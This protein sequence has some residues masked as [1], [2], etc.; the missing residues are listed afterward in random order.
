MMCAELDT[1]NNTHNLGF[2]G[3]M[4]EISTKQEKIMASSALAIKDVLVCRMCGQKSDLVQSTHTES[5]ANS[6]LG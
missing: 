2:G 1:T 3:C 6:S 4:T 5:R